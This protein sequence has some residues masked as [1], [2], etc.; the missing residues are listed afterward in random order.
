MKLHGLHIDHKADLEFVERIYIESFPPDE[1]RP[2]SEFHNLIDTE[3]AFTVFIIMDEDNRI[4]F[5]TLWTLGDFIYAEHFAIAPEYRNEGY[6]KRVMESF[7]DATDIPIILEVELPDTEMA[8]RRIGFYRRAGFRL[9]EI[10]YEQPP[11]E[12]QYDPVPMCLMTL[13]N[14]DLNKDFDKVKDILYKRVYR[15]ND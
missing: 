11:Y 3:K 12:K 8:R 6:G 5:I 14:I 9:W 2:V 1:R 4:G 7:I 15:L 13:R 10:P